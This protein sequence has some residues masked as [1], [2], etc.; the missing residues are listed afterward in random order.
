[1]EDDRTVEFEGEFELKFKDF[2]HSRRNLP[3]LETIQPDLPYSKPGF[4]LKSPADLIDS[5]IRTFDHSI[6]SQRFPRMHAD[7]VASDQELAYRRIAARHMAMRI[8]QPPKP[9]K[10]N[11]T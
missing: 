10:P 4:G 11:Q 7:E 5:I 9:S 1:M 2:P 8:S 6:I 3:L